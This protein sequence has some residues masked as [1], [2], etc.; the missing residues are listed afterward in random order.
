MPPRRRAAAAKTP[1]PDVIENNGL[2]TPGSTRTRGRALE[3]ND[4]GLTPASTVAGSDMEEDQKPEI[5][6]KSEMVVEIPV[7]RSSRTSVAKKPKYT[8][9]EEV[10]EL[11]DKKPIIKDF[12][13]SRKRKGESSLTERSRRTLLNHRFHLRSTVLSDTDLSDLDAPI[14]KKGTSSSNSQTATAK[15]KTRATPARSSRRKVK[16]EDNPDIV[17]DSQEED[18]FTASEEEE[19]YAEFEGDDDEL[20]FMPRTTKTAGKKAPARAASKKA[21]NKMKGKAAAQGNNEDEI[22]EEMMKAAI[23]VSPRLALRYA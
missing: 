1:I 23:A 8:E 12:A 16:S 9:D 15:G 18:N 22:E 11:E 7:K 21:T 3:K 5:K 6:V 19:A 20:D 14:T 17:P 13:T 4:S 2:L 10:D